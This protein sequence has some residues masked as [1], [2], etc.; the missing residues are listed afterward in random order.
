MES[1]EREMSFQHIDGYFPDCP[2]YDKI[3]WVANSLD[4]LVN[5]D[6]LS[7]KEAKNFV[8]SLYDK[9]NRGETK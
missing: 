4:E 6:I 1:L 5:D 9:S 2:G 3:W 8:N 7:E